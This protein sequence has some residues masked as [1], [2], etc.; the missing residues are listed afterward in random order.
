[1]NT[2]KVCYNCRRK[3]PLTNQFFYINKSRKDGFDNRCI[4]CAKHSIKKSQQK[5]DRKDVNKKHQ[6]NRKIRL[7]QGLC[8]FCNTPRLPSSNIYC[9][10]HYLGDMAKK[11]LGTTK[12]WKELKHLLEKQNFKCAYTNET[13]I[14]G[15]NASIDHK[16]PASRFPDLYNDVDNL[17]WV[18][19]SINIMKRDFTNEEFLNIISLV[20]KNTVGT[21]GI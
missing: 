13:L 14:L 19:K 9:E 7:S 10:K 11:H 8:E 2:E 3:L 20:F 5:R 6:E 15:V 1:M 18:T 4:S 12:R 17:Q 16:F 21:T